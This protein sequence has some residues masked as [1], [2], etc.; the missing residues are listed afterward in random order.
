MT[1]RRNVEDLG[2]D[3]HRAIYDGENEIH[4]SHTFSVD[5]M[6]HYG[7]SDSARI[8]MNENGNYRNCNRYT[9][10]SVHRRIDNALTRGS[11]DSQRVSGSS[12]DASYIP[13]QEQAQRLGRQF[14]IASETYRQTG[15]AGCY[16]AM[17]N[18][19]DVAGSELDCDLREF[20]LP[21][22]R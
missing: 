17:Q 5:M 22:R 8:A 1:R 14:D 10:L 18:I 19:R 6:N 16:A 9:N 3:D 2:K 21:K 12:G 15:D 7:L 13:P 20:R 11:Y 4:A